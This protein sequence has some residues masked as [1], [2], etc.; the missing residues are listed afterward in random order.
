MAVALRQGGGEYESEITTAGIIHQ[1]FED[2]AGQTAALI[3]YFNSFHSP[4]FKRV[5]PMLEM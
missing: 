3:N 1:K 4:N 2:K 5:G